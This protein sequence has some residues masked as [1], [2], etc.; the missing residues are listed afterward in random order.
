VN[1]LLLCWQLVAA[2]GGVSLDSLAISGQHIDVAT[3]WQDV[4][5]REPLTAQ[6]GKPRLILYI[7]GL[8]SVGL[9]RDR[10]VEQLP[11]LLPTGTAEAAV[12]NRAGQS[13]SLHMTGYSF[14]RGMPGLVLE[15]DSIP[16]GE[17]FFRL[18]VRA[19]RP[20]GDVVMVW[21]DSLGRSRPD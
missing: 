4:V 11:G 14:F 5:L 18:A 1:A 3:V 12:W 16:K 20:I 13:F 17:T 15:A 6:T 9:D 7:R 21:L 8:D 2:M 10:V 19:Q